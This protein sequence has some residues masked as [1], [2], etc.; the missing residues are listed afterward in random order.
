[1]KLLDSLQFEK[2]NF[3]NRMHDDIT[4]LQQKLAADGV[5]LSSPKAIEKALNFGL[6][7]KDLGP[8]PIFT[9]KRYPTPGELVMENPF[10]ERDKSPSKKKKK[11]KKGAK[12]V[13][14]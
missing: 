6:D 2:T 1:M 5:R 12:T 4:N 14:K 7:Q 11:G 8:T 13:K 9:K 10:W 3:D